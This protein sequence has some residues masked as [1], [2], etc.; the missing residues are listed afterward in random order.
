[1]DGLAFPFVHLAI[2]VAT[3]GLAD[4]SWLGWWLL[5][6]GLYRIAAGAALGAAVGWL[7]SRLVYQAPHDQPIASTGLA[8]VALCIF[9]IAFGAAE[10]T[11]G[12]GFIAAFVCAV[13]LRGAAH[14]HDYNGVLFNFIES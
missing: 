6:D 5:R 4:P 14:N 1:N 2:A 8:S 7:L 12:Y 9:L 3:L 10:L 13:V 11:G